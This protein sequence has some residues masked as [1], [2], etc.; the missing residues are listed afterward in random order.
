[1]TGLLAVIGTIGA[2]AA[3]AAVF[4]PRLLQAE[5]A[6][7]VP[8]AVAAAVPE[9]QTTLD[10]LADL[11]GRS[12]AILAVHQR[13][14]TPYAETV[15]W[16]DDRENQGVIDEGEIAVLSHSEVLWTIVY[17]GLAA[18]DDPERV[19]KGETAIDVNNACRIAFC[20]H[21]R[22]DPRVEPRVIATGVSGMRIEPIGQSGEGRALVR[23]ALTWGSDL[24]D[25]SDEASTVVDVQ[26]RGPDAVE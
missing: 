25:G 20:S 15:L 26:M 5:E 3:T 16:L 12:R 24:T 7:G 18:A 8:E 1:M 21:W 17:H 4:S 10:A 14:V 2:V 19:Q 23:I 9:H 6:E 11:I 13:G 22:S